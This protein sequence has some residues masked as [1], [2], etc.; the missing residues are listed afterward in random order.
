MNDDARRPRF[1][2]IEHIEVLLLEDSEADAKLIEVTLRRSGLAFRAQRID[3]WEHLVRALGGEAHVLLCD[4][5]VP[6]LDPLNV[7]AEVRQRRPDVPVIIVS[8]SIGEDYA[9]AAMRAGADD[10]VLKDRLERLGIAVEQAMERRR[11]ERDRQRAED[12]ARLL[13]RTIDAT[14]QGVVLLDATAPTHPI[15]FANP[16]FLACIGRT[17]AEVL[18]RSLGEALDA[19]PAVSAIADGA[20]DTGD[21]TEGEVL[22]HRKDGSVFWCSLS[23]EALKDGDRHPTHLSA[24]CVDVTER[25]RLEEQFRQMQKMEALGQLAGG[26]AH[27]FNNLLFVINAY[28]QQLSDEPGMSAAARDAVRAIAECGERGTALT[29]QLLLFSRNEFVAPVRV[30]VNATLRDLDR[31]LRRLIREDIT[32]ETKCGPEVTAVRW[33]EGML[34]R[35]LTNL[36]LNARDAMLDGGTI[37]IESARRVLTQ[38]LD[39]PRGSVPAGT[40][41]TIAVT[42]TGIGMSPELQ[43]RLFEPFFTT[44]G[45][46]RGTGLGLAT[47]YGMVSQ[48]GGFIDLR[49]EVGQG[50]TFTI[51]LPERDDVKPPS[52]VDRSALPHG[53][54][55]ILL[56]EDDAR[57]RQ[58]IEE[59]LTA[60]GYRVTSAGDGMRAMEFAEAEMPDLLV[61]DVVMPGMNGRTLA[62]RLRRRR[63]GLPVLFMSGY[64]DDPAHRTSPERPGIAHLQKP[65]S[66]QVLAERVRELLAVESAWPIGG[67]ASGARRKHS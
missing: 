39:T 50:S 21:F 40:Y 66:M 35:V 56:V 49:S 41:I 24:S 62:D 15:V 59:M 30:E 36:V 6:G 67:S 27:D 17:A 47:A 53:S 64:S 1:D 31:M 13:F 46:D 29:R 48:A 55:S 5:S 34:E 58:V 42:D 9:V 11:I 3:C 61:T 22:A 43:E 54:E 63:Q 37:T 45:P 25:R 33:G 51:Y 26:V 4:Y 2:G 32:L 18:G 10:Y 8:G 57:V 12:T 14:R 23:V 20:A 7:I 28:S 38:Q 60:L 19:E 44:K 16:A 65:F 52:T